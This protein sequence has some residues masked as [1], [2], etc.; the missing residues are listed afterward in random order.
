MKYTAPDYETVMLKAVDVFS[1]YQTGCPQDE[2]YYW[3]YTEPCEGTDNWQQ[4]HDTFT[5]IGWA[6][7]CYT[8]NKP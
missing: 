4:A 6:H 7:Q 8:T 1:A 2:D 3:I 5:G